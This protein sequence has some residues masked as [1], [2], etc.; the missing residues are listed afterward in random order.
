MEHS[1]PTKADHTWGKG[2]LFQQQVWACGL[3]MDLAEPSM[4][5]T[6]VWDSYKQPSFFLCL[7]FTGSLLHHS[8]IFSQLFLASYTFCLTSIFPKKSLLCLMLSWH[9]FLK[10][11]GPKQGLSFY[12]D[13]R[14]MIYN[15]LELL[16]SWRV[17]SLLKEE[18]Y[19][20]VEAEPIVSK[21]FKVL[22]LEDYIN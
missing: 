5:S 4:N 3:P 20:H 21:A 6:A 18:F 15:T 7:S 1:K 13:T 2:V 12:N 10:G 17:N 11:S 16:V 19:L 9:L 14:A 8:L 22:T